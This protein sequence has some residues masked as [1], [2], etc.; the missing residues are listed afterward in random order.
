M[1]FPPTGISVV[2]PCRSIYVMT[3]KARYVFKHG[4]KQVRVVYFP[5]PA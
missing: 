5:N 3:N 4:I 2:L 1:Y